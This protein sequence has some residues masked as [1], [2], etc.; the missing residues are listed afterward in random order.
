LGQ[1]FGLQVKNIIVIICWMARRALLEF[2]LFNST[3][4]LPKE[5]GIVAI[6][7]PEMPV[8]VTSAITIFSWRRNASCIFSVM[9]I[10]VMFIEKKYL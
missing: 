7:K 9:S 2:L 4:V 8:S 5:C 6:C 1:E 10:K 3:Q